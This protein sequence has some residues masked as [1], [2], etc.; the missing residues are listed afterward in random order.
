MI[1]KAVFST[2]SR[3][4]EDIY[5]PAEKYSAAVSIVVMLLLV[6]SKAIENRAISRAQ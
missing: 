3:W 6:S 1:V 5:L 4:G 2:G